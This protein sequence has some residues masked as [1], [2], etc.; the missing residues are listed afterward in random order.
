MSRYW[1]VDE[2][3][4]EDERVPIKWTSDAKSVGYLD[5][6]SGSE[7]VQRGTSMEVPLWLAEELKSRRLADV[8][9]PAHFSRKSRAQITA[10]ATAARLR[11]KS[12]HFYSV[13]LRLAPLLSVPHEGEDLSRDVHATL[14]DRAA[15]ILNKAKTGLG[16]DVS[17]YRGMLTDLE[18]QLFDAASA[19]TAAK[20]QWRQEEAN[21]LRPP[22][23]ALAGLEG[24]GGAA[25]SAAS[26]EAAA[27]SA[28]TL[29]VSR[30]SKRQRS[31]LTTSGL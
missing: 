31:L 22:A 4:A 23:A 13:G 11:E 27:I 19:F 30:A 16:G 8:E 10:D 2:M 28:S 7:D 3:L 15:G 26:A 25:A 17:V 1:S 12:P 5:P 24:G 29:P 18:Q 6:S 14:A 20:F 9:L 21:Y